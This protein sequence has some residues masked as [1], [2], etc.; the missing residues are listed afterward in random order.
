M[1]LAIHCLA[2][3]DYE[4]AFDSV[5]QEGI[6]NSLREQGINRHIKLLQIFY[7]NGTA[8]VRLHKDSDKVKI[9]KGVRQG[10]TISPKL[11]T[12][13]LESIFRKINWERK[14]LNINGQYLNHL[15]FADDII[16]MS[17]TAEELQDML[18]DLKRESLKAGLKMNRSKTKVMSN[19]K[20]QNAK[21]KIDEILQEV[22]EYLYL[23]QLLTLDRDY[24]SEIKRRITIGWKVFGKHCQIMKSI[25]LEAEKFTISVYS[26]L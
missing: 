26:H 22:N 4:E 3:V 25:L 14:G 7:A 15:R 1:N 23:G 6:L 11:F 8:T 13:C 2:F 10:D 20:A 16:L 21:I 5:E 12:A 18:I 9:A 24:E 19:S 17:E